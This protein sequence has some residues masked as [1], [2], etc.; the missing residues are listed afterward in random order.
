MGKIC[1]KCK[2]PKPITDFALRDKTKPKGR[3]GSY[4]SECMKPYRKEHY[5]SNPQPYKSRSVAKKKSDQKW[6]LQWLSTRSCVDCGETD[7]VVLECDHVRGTKFRSIGVML[8]SNSR[9]SLL[10]ELDKC[11]VRCANCHKR[12]TAR[13]RGSYRL[14]PEA[15]VAGGIPNPTS[16]R[17]DP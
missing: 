10:E 1:A 17:F 12:K 5:H 11:E 9:E 6:F 16:T 2:E 8:R 13:E 4:C 3:R 14:R 7:P 15:E